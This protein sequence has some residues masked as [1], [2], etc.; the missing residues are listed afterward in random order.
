[1]CHALWIIHEVT[2]ICTKK[3]LAG[4]RLA[5]KI[6]GLRP[7]FPVRAD[8]GLALCHDLGIV[9]EFA[10]ICTKKTLAGCRFT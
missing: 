5:E 3:T 9:H 10:R 4:C 2:R 8:G 1:L 6:I 7:E